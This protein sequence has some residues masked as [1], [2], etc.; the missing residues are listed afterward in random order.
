LQFDFLI[1][2]AHAKRIT[3]I[4]ISRDNVKTIRDHRKVITDEREL[5][6]RVLFDQTQNCFGR[7]LILEL[8]T[9]SV[10]KNL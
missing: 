2:Q 6:L 7:E 4:S 1:A 5:T 10:S 3:L 8:L 9:K